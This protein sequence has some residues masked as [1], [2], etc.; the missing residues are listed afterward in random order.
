MDLNALYS[1]YRMLVGRLVVTGAIGYQPG[2]EAYVEFICYLG[3]LCL[4]LYSMWKIATQ[5]LLGPLELLFPGSD[6]TKSIPQNKTAL[7]IFALFAVHLGLN[8]YQATLQVPTSIATAQHAK[9]DAKTLHELKKIAHRH[10]VTIVNAVRTN[11][12]NMGIHAIGTKKGVTIYISECWFETEKRHAQLLVLFEQK[13][14][15]LKNHSFLKENVV[16][17]GL[18]CLGTILLAHLY[19]FPPTSIILLN[20]TVWNI[21][22]IA[23]SAYKNYLYSAFSR[24]QIY[25]NDQ[26]VATIVGTKRLCEALIFFDS[27]IQYDLATSKF[28]YWKLHTP[29]FA[30]RIAQLQ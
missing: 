7:I 15:E 27:V 30:D 1:Q 13:A 2:Y 21:A 19:I 18:F 28:P 24:W 10:G 26:E 5:H 23:T 6:E 22:F 14:V 17:S 16:E 4:F 12:K 9:L 11:I 20:F 8:A 29:Q 25:R 3:I